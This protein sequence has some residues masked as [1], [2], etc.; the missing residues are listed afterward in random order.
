MKST[1]LDLLGVACLALFA[2]SVWPPACLLVVGVAALAMA[3]VTAEDDGE[4][5]E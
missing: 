5:P 4:E 1:I 2:F 3:W